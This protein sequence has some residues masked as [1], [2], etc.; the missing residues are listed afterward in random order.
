MSSVTQHALHPWKK[1]IPIY[2]IDLAEGVGTP[3][4]DPTVSGGLSPGWL[5]PDAA[6]VGLN[7]DIMVP[8]DWIPGTDIKFYFVYSPND[9]G[10]TGNIVLGI[11]YVLYPDNIY[12]GGLGMNPART[13]R[14]LVD[15]PPFGVVMKL[16]NTYVAIPG[17][18]LKGMRQIQIAFIRAGD[19]A[20]DTDNRT[21]NLIKVIMEYESY[22]P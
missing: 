9:P 10:G 6:R 14:V 11:D 19:L 13:V 8:Y 22:Q 16:T 2:A 12:S 1:K 7:A 18:D 15:T 4:W 21:H 3:S 5:M 20:E 17:R